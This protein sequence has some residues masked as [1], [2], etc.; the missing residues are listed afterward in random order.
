MFGAG[1]INASRWCNHNTHL[2]RVRVL[3]HVNSWRWRNGLRGIVQNF[4]CSSK[5]PSN[6]NSNIFRRHIKVLSDEDHKIRIL[7]I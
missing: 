1:A 3:D 4:R 7:M 6:Y 5:T 2:E